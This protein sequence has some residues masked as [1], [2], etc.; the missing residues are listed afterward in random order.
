MREQVVHI[1]LVLGAITYE[2]VRFGPSWPT[3]KEHIWEE[4]VPWVLALS[5]VVIWHS[6]QAAIQLSRDIEVESAATSGFE[7]SQILTSAGSKF[8][9][10]LRTQPTQRVPH[11]QVWGSAVCV[12]LLCIVCSLASLA[13]SL[14]T[15]QQTRQDDDHQIAKITVIGVK[16][17]PTP[18]DGTWPHVN[19]FYQ[20]TGAMTAHAVSGRI[21]TVVKPYKLSDI[22][23]RD[24]QD[25]LSMWPSDNWLALLRSKKGEE[26]ERGAPGQ[27]F[28]FPDHESEE[29]KMIGVTLPR[30]LTKHWYAYV[31][32]I[33]KYWDD[34]MEETTLGVKE[35]CIF[36]VNDLDINRTCGRTRTF[37]E[38]QPFTHA[39][40]LR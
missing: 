17:V 24:S 19:V 35:S 21:S 23:I 15:D 13:L 26:L 6:I 4:L 18:V 33:F 28:S 32:V 10:P 29:S 3:F 20:N 39:S 14:K 1:L 7:E 40:I 16:P 25:G 38:K 2:V 11:I 31:L 8:R 36:F 27:W 9:V 22:E 12:M 34:S 37:L 5:V 30:V